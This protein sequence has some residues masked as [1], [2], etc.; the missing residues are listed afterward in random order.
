MKLCTLHV[1]YQTY[2]LSMKFAFSFFFNYIKLLSNKGHYPN[3]RCQMMLL[4]WSFKCNVF[5]NDLIK[6]YVVTNT[7]NWYGSTC[8]TFYRQRVIICCSKFIDTD[9]HF[10]FKT[11][12]NPLIEQGLM[13]MCFYNNKIVSENMELFHISHYIFLFSNRF[14]IV[15]SVN[16]DNSF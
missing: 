15:C 10:I 2:I 8:I 6:S 11:K 13:N 14:C 9:S 4:L 12:L 1:V 7:L 5:G 3:D 16:Y